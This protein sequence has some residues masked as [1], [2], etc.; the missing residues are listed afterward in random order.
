[1]MHLGCLGMRVCRTMTGVLRTYADGPDRDRWNRLTKHLLRTAIVTFA[2][3][4][5]SATPA[6]A[7]RESTTTPL[8]SQT[9]SYSCPTCHSLEAGAASPTVAP[10]T[11]PST[12]TWDSEA[13]TSVGT[14]KGPHGGYTSGTQKCQTCHTI[15]GAA[16]FSLALLPMSTIYETCNTCHDGTGGGGVYGVVKQ[17]TGIQPASEHRIGTASLNASG[18]VTLPGGDPATGGSINT[19]FTGES[20]S[21]TCT[22]CHSPHNSKT[23]NPFRGDRV[24]SANDT[25]TIIKTNRLLRQRPTKATTGTTEYGSDWCQ[26]CHKGR[27]N[28][29]AVANHPAADASSTPQNGGSAWYY[30]RVEGVSGYGTSSVITTQLGG[31]NFGFIM[32]E[33]RNSQTY[34]LCQQCHEDARTIGDVTQFQVNSVTESFTPSLDGT[35]TSGN[36]RFQNFPHES[37]NEFF[38][39]ETADDLCTNC[40]ISP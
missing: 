17:R 9:P 7:Y 28:T 13:G 39:V 20:G 29:G 3:V 38:L 10:R 22:D 40:H 30:G 31:S 6:L 12:W 21:L 35:S 14:R 32:P 11:V 18:T 2:F 8:P 27:H 34:P 37:V 24:R 23:V 4:A 15:H 26:A 5:V 36:P 16:P 19:T 33:P 25:T 1:M